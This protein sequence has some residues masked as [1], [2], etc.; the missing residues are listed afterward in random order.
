V[1]DGAVRATL[2]VTA[3]RRHFVVTVG[4]SQDS[5]YARARTGRAV[6]RLPAP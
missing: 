5:L 4:W 1:T 3:G 6:L 2:T